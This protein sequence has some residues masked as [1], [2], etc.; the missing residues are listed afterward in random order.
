MSSFEYAQPETARSAYIHVPFCARRCGYCNFTLVAGR[1]DL[2]EP[3]LDALARELSFLQTP[4]PVE[5]L[6]LGGGTPTQLKGNA[7]RRLLAIV[8]QWHPLAFGPEFSVEA[9]PEDL[10]MQTVEALAEHGVTRVSL[11]AQSFNPEKLRSLERE[12]SSADNRRSVELLRSKRLDVSIDLIFAA[13]GE[14]LDGWRSDLES[15]IALAPDHISTYG[16]TIERGTQFWNRQR[17][18][19]ISSASEELDRAMYETAID[20]LSAAGFEHYEVS[21]FARKG[22]RCR[23][24]EAYWLG[25]EY[26]AAGPGAARY[27]HG[28]RSVNHRST[29]TYLG[30]V[31]AGKSPISDSE[32]LNPYERALEV[33][34]FALRRREGVD[35]EWF[36]AKTGKS[37]DSL[38]GQTLQPLIEQKLMADNGRQICLTRDGLLVSDSICS[39][40]LTAG[41]VAV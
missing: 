6:F 39:R 33:L 9:N 3:Y 22:K 18:G 35:R 26:Y 13:P 15:A 16:L 24:N 20:R 40:L 4:K 1:E 23:H 8:L 29:T 14:T 36:K 2:I 21:N 32:E 27:L 30:R 7:L 19:A 31:L 10:D 28:V 38:V 34:V 25:E 12:H 17:R 37:L 11:G 5:T 41:R